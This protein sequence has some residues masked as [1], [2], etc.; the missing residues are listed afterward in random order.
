M[1]SPFGRVFAWFRELRL[2]AVP[3]A[4]HDNRSCQGA[5]WRNA[6][7]EASSQDI[8]DF[9]KIFVGA[10]P[11]QPSSRLNFSP[12]GSLL[13]IYRALYPSRWAPDALELETF[14][15]Q[16]ER[17]YGLRFRDDW[18]EE[19]TLGQLFAVTISDTYGE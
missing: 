8:R 13:A 9:L 6:F 19:L 11:F 16:V 14:S 12:D 3:P 15:Q 4:P 7:P 1:K 10:F 2:G 18:Q 5:A 17:R